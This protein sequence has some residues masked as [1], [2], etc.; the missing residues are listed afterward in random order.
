MFQRAFRF[1]VFGFAVAVSGAVGAAGGLLSTA[2]LAFVFAWAGWTLPAGVGWV[3]GY[4]GV[5]V[6]TAIGIGAG[7]WLLRSR[8]EETPP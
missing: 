3:L 1:A 8:G 2:G 7:A 6:W 5:I 4:A